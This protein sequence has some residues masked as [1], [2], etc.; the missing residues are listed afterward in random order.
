MSNKLSS[1]CW[2]LDT[3]HR[4]ITPCPQRF[5]EKRSKN[6]TREK[7]GCRT[8]QKGKKYP[9]VIGVGDK[10][11]LGLQDSILPKSN[12]ICQLL[13]QFCPNLIKFDQ[14]WSILSNKKLYP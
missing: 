4:A 10:I 12:Q 6:G 2:L 3:I 11:F 5:N 1:L 13:P 14:I 9:V 8:F 7:R